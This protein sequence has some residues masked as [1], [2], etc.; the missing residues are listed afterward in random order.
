M[1]FPVLASVIIPAYNCEAY[2][3]EAIDSILAQT[4]TNFELILI[5]DNSTDKTWPLMGTY[6]EKDNRIIIL[7][8]QTNLG[9]ARSRNL[10]IKNA[11]GKYIVTFDADD[12][13]YPERI[14]KQIEYLE[15]NPCV[16][17][18]G[19]SIEI[20]TE[21]LNH[22]NYRHYKQTDQEIRDI[23]FFYSPFAHPA[24]VF[25]KEALT[26]AGGYNENLQVAIDYDIYFRVGQHYKLANLPIPLLKLRT[27]D[28]SISQRKGNMQE[29]NTLY[30]RLKAVVELKYRMTLLAKL[31]FLAQVISSHCLPFKVRFWVFNFLRRGS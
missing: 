17:V 8:N 23:M 25:S 14:E 22:I 16:G 13:A 6:R 2:L 26:R 11:A 12:W 10:G 24:T 9:I 1:S 5:D 28:R 31:Y 29:R 3:G 27:H 21:S 15:A 18:L 20:C 7:R 19:S 4:F 30:I